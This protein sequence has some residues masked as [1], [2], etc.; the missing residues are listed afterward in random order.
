MAG[1]RSWLVASAVIEGPDGILLVRNR[2]RDGA[3]DWSLP[4][5]VIDEGEELL[6][7]LAREVTEETGLQ[8]GGWEGP[9]WEV[10]AHAPDM[11][12]ELRVEVH[13]AT[14]YSGELAFE[15]PDGIV[16]D[17]RFF[18]V[19]LCAEPLATT[20]VPTHEPINAWLVE[21]WAESRLF[22]Y[23]VLGTTRAEMTFDRL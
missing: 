1:M 3:V 9:L 2:R 12:W 10:E 16:D 17:A 4:G 18:H 5:G 20:W 14:S 7:G 13:R 11:G 8:V 22:R 6:D 23:R 19:E 15:D 21:R